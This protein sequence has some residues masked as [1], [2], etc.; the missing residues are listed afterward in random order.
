M[1]TPVNHA[2]SPA[3][4]TIYNMHATSMQHGCNINHATCMKAWMQYQSCNMHEAWMQQQSCNMHAT[5]ESCANHAHK[6]PATCFDKRRPS[7]VCSYEFNEFA[8]GNT[9]D[10]H[11]C[12]DP[13]AQKC[14]NGVCK[15]T[16]M[17]ASA[18]HRPTPSLHMPQ[19]SLIKTGTKPLPSHKDACRT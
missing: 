6:K 8:F 4:T 5:H 19:K 3:T 10:I 16:L 2:C 17:A 11:L 1:K 18:S 14:K 15:H 13:N 9:N 7:I 12:Q